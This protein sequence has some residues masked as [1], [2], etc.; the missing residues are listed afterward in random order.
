MLPRL[1][2]LVIGHEVVSLNHPIHVLA[3]DD[4]LYSVEV[5]LEKDYCLQFIEHDAAKDFSRST[6]KLFPRLDKGFLSRGHSSAF[7][8]R[9]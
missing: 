7:E 4:L 2:T 8:R 1:S 6:T 9:A 3:V 5:R